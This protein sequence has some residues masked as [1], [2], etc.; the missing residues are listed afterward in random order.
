MGRI[1]RAGEAAASVVGPAL[2]RAEPAAPRASALDRAGAR[3]ALVHHAPEAGPAGGDEAGHRQRPARPAAARSRLAR[4]LPA[5]RATN[6]RVLLVIL[7]VVVLGVSV[8]GTAVGLWGRWRATLAS[9]RVQVAVR[10]RVFEHAV[11]LPLHRVYQ[12]KS[13]G[14][15]SLLR[16]DA[17]GVG[18]LIFS[19]LYNPWRAVVQ[20]AGR[21]GRAGL[22]RLA[23]P[24][25]RARAWRRRVLLDRPALEPPAPAALSRRPQAAT[26]DRR[27]GRRG[28]RRD[29]GRPRLRPPAPRI[30]PGSSARTTSWP[31]RSCSPGGG[32]AS[33]RS[34]GTCSCPA[35][36]PRC[37]STAAC[38]VL[39][40]TALA[41]RPDDVPG[42][43]GDA[44]RAAGRAR[45][46]RPRSSR[47]TSSGFDRVLDLLA[48]PREMADHPGAPGRPQELVPGRITLEGVE[49]RLSRDRPPG[50]PRH[51]PRRRAG[52]G[53]RP[54]RPQRRG[55]DDALQPGRPV[56]RPD[57]RG[58]PARRRR[59]P[60]DPRSRATAAC[61]GSSSRTS[62]S[63][64]A[65]SP[66]TSPTPTAAR[67]GPRSSAPRGSPTPTSS[68]RPCP[69]VTTP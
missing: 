60:R 18:E 61:S 66:R 16:E 65:R 24:A 45:H 56:P 13:G 50:A 39:D 36:R 19:M 32:P 8:L 23:A 28:V 69:R 49:L 54:G 40:G 63:S 53:H 52:R 38:R 42:L 58:H 1:R 67:L 41:R 20:L 9:K 43:P 27:H 57:R 34:S 3:A 35:P 48:E 31:A 59:P 44:P 2:P 22:G 10:R 12:L 5:G 29:A 30:V 15:A 51:R 37:C 11:R 68:S 26:G 46:Q 6:P 25:R 4:W 14:A 55:Q 62:S 33:S 21:A 47:T 64:T 17:G 7:A